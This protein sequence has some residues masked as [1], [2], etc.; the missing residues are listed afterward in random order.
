MTDHD[1]VMEVVQADDYWVTIVQEPDVLADPYAVRVDKSGRCFRIVQA[2]NCERGMEELG[3]DMHVCNIYMFI[4]CLQEAR[5][6][7]LERWGDD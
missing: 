7:V 6:I 5:D 3:E 1:R 2:E 4:R